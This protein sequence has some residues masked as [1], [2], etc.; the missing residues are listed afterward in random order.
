M[1]VDLAWI[2][3]VRGAQKRFTRSPGS[4]Y[5]SAGAIMSDVSVLDLFWLILKFLAALGMVCLVGLLIYLVWAGAKRAA[6]ITWDILRGRNT[7]VTAIV[8]FAITVVALVTGVV[9]AA[10]YVNG[11]LKLFR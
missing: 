1:T 2:Q 9:I 8:V 11:Q 6:T 3:R 4:L 5:F 10:G 7:S